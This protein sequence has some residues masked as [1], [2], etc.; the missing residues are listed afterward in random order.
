MTYTIASVF[1][2]VVA[3]G[4]MLHARRIS[5]IEGRSHRAGRFYIL[6]AGLALF[7]VI[8]LVIDWASL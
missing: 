8:L 6:G 1:V 2:I 7:V 3:I 5:G 4:L